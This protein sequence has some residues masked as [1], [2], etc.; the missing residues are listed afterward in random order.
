MLLL[1]TSLF[2]AFSQP[3]SG[4]NAVEEPSETVNEEG[5]AENNPAATANRESDLT[6]A[7]SDGEE[8]PDDEPI[9]VFGIG[10]LI[11]MVLVLALVVGIIYAL[12]FFLKRNRKATEAE[13]SFITILSTQTLPGGRQLYIIDVAGSVYLLGAGDGGLSL[14]TEIDDK[15]TVDALRLESSRQQ[16]QSRN[17]AQLMSTFFLKNSAD[18]GASAQMQGSGFNFIHEQRK[19]LKK[20]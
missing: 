4:D 17:F 13:S 9:Q 18:P 6:F 16:L 8:V 12:A 1:I 3:V 10:D 11:R 20:L 14:I 5:V 2:G 7:F 15:P 19:R